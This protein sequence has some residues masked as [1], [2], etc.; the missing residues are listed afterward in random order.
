[1]FR[2]GYRTVKTALG[3]AIAIAIAYYLKLDFY[4]SAGIITI[5]CIQK[6]RRQSIKISWERLLACVVGLLYASILFELF[7]YNPITIAILL[8][9]FIPTTVVLKAQEGIATSSVIILHV[10]TSGYVST[11]LIVNELA[12]IVIGIGCAL[13]MNVYMPSVERELQKQQQAV[14][15]LFSKIFHEFAVYIRYGD[16]NWDGK[17]ITEVAKILQDAKNTALNNVENHILRYNDQYY[18][19]FKMREKQLDIIER[20]MPL[21]TSIEIQV[22]QGEMLGGFMEELSEGVT[23]K[24][25]A[26]LYLEKLEILRKKYKEM[27]L[28]HARDE[29]ETRSALLYLAYEIEQYLLVKQQFQPVQNY[30]V[31]R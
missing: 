6:T 1:M 30:S 28:P 25:T 5:L 14:E 27:P 2:I 20:M 16:R 22:K 19:Y 15:R 21:L 9:L 11:S 13:L 12:I 24:N 10:F 4:A 8:L 17:E 18:H 3:A 26:T 29:F 31:F 7:G 23:P